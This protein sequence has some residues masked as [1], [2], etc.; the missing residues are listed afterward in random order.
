MK[1]LG[2]LVVGGILLIAVWYFFIYPADYVVAFNANALP[3]TIN[4]TLKTWNG[5]I[6]GDI[7]K[8]DDLGSVTQSLKF[9]DSTHIYQWKF[10][11]ISDTSSRVSVS[12]K[13]SEHS[14]MNRIKKPFGDISIEKRS[15]STAKDFYDYLNEHLEEFKITY[16]GESEI[17]T[18]YCAYISLSGKQVTKASGMMR[19]Y[20]LLN[21]LLYH[22]GISLN[23]PPFIEVTYW[24]MKTDSINYNFCFPII[25]SEKLPEHPLV[26]YKRLFSKKALKATYNGNYITSDR[27]WYTLL[28]KAEEL[29]LKAAPKPIEFFYNNPKFDADELNWKAEIYLPLKE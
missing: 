4:Q 23:G 20:N 6:D 5:E 13:D 16:D 24:D 27:A 21:G 15:A 26:K 18:T 12:I 9:N 10:E 11:A 19:N 1:K 14:F 8:N 28:H 3:G 22:N 7:S 2:F 29:G 17:P 25:R